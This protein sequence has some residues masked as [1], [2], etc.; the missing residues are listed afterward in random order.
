MFPG[1]SQTHDEVS[2]EVA[3]GARPVPFA[4]GLMWLCGLVPLLLDDPRRRFMP[5]I[6][7]VTLSGVGALGLVQTAPRRW[8]LGLVILALAARGF[9]LSL[10]PAFSEDVFRYVYEGRVAGWGGFLFPYTHPPADGPALG[11][12]TVLLDEAWLRINHPELATIYPPLAMAV[13]SAS[14]GLAHWLSASSL[15]VLKAVLVAADLTTWRLLHLLHPRA[16]WLWGLAPL[17]ILEG[18]REGHADVLSACGLAAGAWAL[19]RGRPLGAYAGWWS[20]GLAK[21]NGLVL[22]PLLLRVTRRGAWVSIPAA[23]L[24]A[25][26]YLLSLGETS[27]LSA[28]AVRWR[29][30]DGAFQVLLGLAEAA[31][32]GDWAHIELFGRPVTLTRHQ[33]ARLMVASLFGLTYLVVLARPALVLGRKV[34]LSEVPALAG[35]LFV[36]LLLLGPT[37]HPWYVLWAL[38]FAAAFEFPGRK[39]VLWL[40]ISA[41]A[42][43]HPGWLELVEGS[44]R[45]LS[46]VR[47]W[48][49][50]P[51]W[52]LLGWD[53]WSRRLRG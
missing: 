6:I 34:T 50:A 10:P 13:F 38:P 42:L 47:I 19:T 9:A 36:V 27:G 44:W 24:L 4:F 29:A 22:L 33:L 52:G 15:W 5:F 28:Y 20:A 21:L 53:L 48:V 49:H 32:G 26:P 39:S 8:R 1:R 37:L 30:G 11:V 12:P 25:L 18:A 14:A 31:L 2:N 23:L 40:A 45:E 46:A 51:A 43:H 17:V 41:P 16:G 7:A 35:L 3:T